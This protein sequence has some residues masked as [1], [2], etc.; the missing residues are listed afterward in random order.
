MFVECAHGSE[1]RTVNTDSNR[2]CTVTTVDLHYN[3]LDQFRTS[4]QPEQENGVLVR[5]SE[6][7]RERQHGQH[8]DCTRLSHWTFGAQSS[9]SI[10]TRET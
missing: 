6:L 8:A 3:L 9:F 10:I 2:E 7:Y 5:N 1:P 4:D